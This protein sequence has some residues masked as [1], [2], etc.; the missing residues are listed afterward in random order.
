MAWVPKRGTF[1][2]IMSDTVCYEVTVS[3]SALRWAGEDFRPGL[4]RAIITDYGRACPQH[5][6]PVRKRAQVQAL[7]REGIHDGGR[8]GCVEE[9]QAAGRDIGFK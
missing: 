6:V 4:R 7:L 9:T 1:A 2:L 5:A 3:G 8:T